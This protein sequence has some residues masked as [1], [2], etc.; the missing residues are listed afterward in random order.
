MTNRDGRRLAIFGKSGSGKSYIA[1][2]MV[3]KAGRV[4]VFDPKGSWMKY[5]GFEI[6]EDFSKVLQFL[7]DMGDAAF[8]AV[9]LPESGLEMKRLSTLSYLLMDAQNDYFHEKSNEKLTFVVDELADSFPL[10]VGMD[11][12]GFASACQKGR[13]FGLNVIGITQRPATVSTIFRGNL[14]EIISFDFSFPADRKAIAEAMEDYS[15][16]DAV[17]GLQK[18]SY[19][20]WRGGE[21][22]KLC[23]KA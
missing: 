20:H 22:F 6:I 23:E 1:E 3:E 19:L 14:D 15:V 10:S 18:Y 16:I 9:Y 11:R 17:Q 4:F 8:R 21:G 5:Q 2:K 13:E 7:K 12:R